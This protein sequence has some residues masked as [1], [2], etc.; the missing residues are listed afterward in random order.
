MTRVTVSRKSDNVETEA[1]RLYDEVTA[2]KAAIEKAI[3]KRKSSLPRVKDV[4]EPS[5]VPAGHLAFRRP[6]RSS[7]ITGWLDDC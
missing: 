1:K 7:P 3:N 4:P 2:L 6:K 5:L